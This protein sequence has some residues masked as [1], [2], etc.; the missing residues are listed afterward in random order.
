MDCRKSRKF[1]YHHNLF[2]CI[3]LNSRFKPSPYCKNLK[4]KKENKKKNKKK[5]KK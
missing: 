2:V 3:K 5:K 4:Q 1:H